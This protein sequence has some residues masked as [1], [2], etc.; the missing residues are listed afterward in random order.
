[1]T[2]IFAVLLFSLLI[3]VHE[4][5]HF[6][7]AKLSG[8]QV[9]EFAMFMGPAIFKKK[10]GET[11]YTVRC[12]PFGGYCAMEGEDADTDS[13]RSFLKAAWW[14]R[15]IILLSGAAMNF[16]IG[17]ALFAIVFAPARWFTE[18]VI[19]MAEDG[20]ALFYDGGL[21]VGDRFL[22]V[23]GEKIYTASDFTMILSLNS[24]DV[25]DLVIEREGKTVILDNFRMEKRAFTD[26]DGVM[27]ERYGFTFAVTKATFGVK[28][29]NTWNSAVDGVRLVRMSLQMMLR[30][31]LGMRDIGGPVMIVDQ[32]NQV[33][34]ESESA[35]DALL[36][37]LYYGAVIAINLAVMNLLPLPALD[38]GRALCV[39]LT[40]AAEAAI[41]RKINPKYE[42][43]LHGAGMVILL[44]LMALVMFKDIFVLFRR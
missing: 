8:V 27:R 11:L 10:K 6:T 42:A 30:G 37:M 28:L 9:N 3:F 7:A 21:Q 4:L 14:K 34:A 15:L 22:K 12:I 32:M 35:G 43:Y 38:G 44:I 23:D 24:G 1:M 17:L 20:S 40:T 39:L 26:E 31:Q 18:P 5:G 2:V 13:E 25:H 36:N 41:G 33:A 19:A 29:K 16:V